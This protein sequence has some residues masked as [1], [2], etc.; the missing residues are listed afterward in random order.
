MASTVP[1]IINPPQFS[2]QPGV[3][4]AVTSV[5]TYSASQLYNYGDVVTY[6]G[7]YFVNFYSYGQTAPAPEGAYVITTD[8][9]VSGIFGGT[10]TNPQPVVAYWAL[11][12]SFIPDPHA[13]NTANVFNYAEGDVVYYPDN[14]PGQTFKFMKSPQVLF[15]ALQLEA[16]R[17]GLNLLTLSGNDLYQSAPD[18][19]WRLLGVFP[20]PLQVIYESAQATVPIDP[21]WSPLNTINPFSFST[22][23]GNSY[24]NTFTGLIDSLLK[25]PLPAVQPQNTVATSLVVSPTSLT[26]GISEEINYSRL[27]TG[28][29]NTENY[30][31]SLTPDWTT[32]STLKVV[33]SNTAVVIAGLVASGLPYPV[34]RIT[35]VSNGSATITL[36]TNDGSNLSAI[37]NVIVST[38]GITPKTIALTVGQTATITQSGIPPFSFVSSS[39]TVATVTNNGTNITTVTALAV[40][41]STINCYNGTQVNAFQCPVTVTAVL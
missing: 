36:T 6:N 33:S 35:G 38:P 1:N 28:D 34:L 4:V 24:L 22:V 3:P 16:L 20:I 40:G 41:V 12:G 13:F 31:Y 23:G 11:M 10:F 9:L 8:S 30:Y 19:F 32:N 37:I 25:N 2:S 15:T 21:C 17:R 5:P 7:E 14:C 26:M 18:L 39:P 29:Q 27:I